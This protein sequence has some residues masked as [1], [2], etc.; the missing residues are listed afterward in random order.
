MTTGTPSAVRGS[1]SE[2]SPGLP[3]PSVGVG[4]IAIGTRA[5]LVG[6]LSALVP[7]CQ[8]YQV[9]LVVVVR[10]ESDAAGETGVRVCVAGAE[11]S[12]GDLRRRA[13]EELPTDIVVLT[14]DAEPLV[15]D[16][17]AALPRLAQLVVSR[18]DEVPA[19]D[20][21]GVLQRHAAPEP[22]A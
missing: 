21:I 6:L 20:W 3:V 2:P 18:E 13:L 8:E 12:E 22:E 4:V 17:S 19:A 5:E 15:A 14:S 1:D 9:E 16:W 11:A 7:A 10:R